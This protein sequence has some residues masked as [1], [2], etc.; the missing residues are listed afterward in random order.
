MAKSKD[1]KAVSARVDEAAVAGAV[2]FPAM[3]KA[4]ERLERDLLQADSIAAPSITIRFFADG[5][6]ELHEETC[7]ET[8]YE[9]ETVEQ[10]F[11]FCRA[12]AVT[13]LVM[14]QGSY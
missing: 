8:L 11:A 3:L 13:R 14:A 2:L 12:G 1:K 5:T 6:G 4:V 10:A 7:D 9:F